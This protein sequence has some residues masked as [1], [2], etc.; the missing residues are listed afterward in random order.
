MGAVL[1]KE[2]YAADA[3]TP[4]TL[5]QIWLPSLLH[6]RQDP[7]TRFGVS[8]P[9]KLLMVFRH[10]LPPALLPQ[11]TPL[12]RGVNP[13]RLL[14]IVLRLEFYPPPKGEGG[15]WAITTPDE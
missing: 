3:D 1:V 14:Q 10:T 6:P 12:S 13:Q 8:L 9:W 11:G 4:G 5:A 7:P 15:C 2:I